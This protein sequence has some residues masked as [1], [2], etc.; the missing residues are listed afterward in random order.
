MKIAPQVL[1]DVFCWGADYGQLKMEEEREMEEYFD[2]AVCL[3]AAKKYHVPSAPARRRQVHSEK[4]FKAK[5]ESYRKWLD[6]YKRYCEETKN[7]SI[8]GAL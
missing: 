3:R 4:W 7:K 8:E 1:L 5:R 2:A 6:F